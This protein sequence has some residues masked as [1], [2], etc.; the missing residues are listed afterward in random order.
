MWSIVRKIGLGLLIFVLT[1]GFGSGVGLADDG[2]ARPAK[3]GKFEIS[4]SSVGMAEVGDSVA[5]LGYTQIGVS[6]K[7]KGFSFGYD[8][9]NYEWSNPGSLPFVGGG[10]DPFEQMHTLKVGYEFKGRFNDTT[11]WR[12]FT[13][14]SSSFENDILGLP[15]ATLGVGVDHRVSDNLILMG[16]A[17]GSFNDSENRAW[18]YIGLIYRPGA[19][20]GISGSLAFPYSR[21]NFHFHPSAYV[22]LRGGYLR[23]T[24]KLAEDNPVRPDG[25]FRSTEFSAGLSLN[26]IVSRM[27]RLEIGA[28]YLFAREITLSDDGGDNST[29]YDLD[30]TWGFFGRVVL[31]F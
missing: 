5:E 30:S 19:R 28:D 14:L 4:V 12:V 21:L 25:E 26:W 27:M 1:L 11:G 9:R 13:R 31:S 23:R 17:F 24:Y 16:G 8:L 20:D 10:D 15:T 2:Q 6:M 3:A 7:L 22:S 18:P 29:D